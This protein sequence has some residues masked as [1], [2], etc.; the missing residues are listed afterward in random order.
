MSTMDNQSLSQ[1]LVE[2]AF[3]IAWNAKWEA[4][5]EYDERMRAGEMVQEASQIIRRLEQK[6]G[7]K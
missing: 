5:I 3:E 7:P 1:R 4:P 6:K 2:L